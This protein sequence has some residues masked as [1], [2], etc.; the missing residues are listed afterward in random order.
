[1]K[2]VVVALANLAIATSLS[3]QS[4]DLDSRIDREM[5]SLVDTYKKLH[6]SP[7][8]SGHEE[9]TSAWLAGELR[10][11]GYTVTDHIGK[12]VEPD[13]VGYGVAGVLKNGSGPTVLVRTELD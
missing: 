9:H 12:Y 4:S 11:L 13:L 6:L 2:S 7:E 8:L 3:A 10:T 5:P 1:M